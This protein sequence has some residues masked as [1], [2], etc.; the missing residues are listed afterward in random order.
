MI[1]PSISPALYSPH[2]PQF[3][4]SIMPEIFHFKLTTI[5]S[6]LNLH[7]L[8][9][10]I[11]VPQL[12]LESHFS[13]PQKLVCCL[14]HKEIS[15]TVEPSGHTYFVC[16]CAQPL[17]IKMDSRNSPKIVILIFIFL[18]SIFLIYL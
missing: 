14:E 10:L 13:S 5:S 16:C 17:K 11:Q 18:P 4:P 9:S 3:T 1:E 2:L 8:Q 7:L 6:S 15:E 12:S